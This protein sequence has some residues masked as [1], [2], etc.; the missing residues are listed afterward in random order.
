MR[1]GERQLLS[2]TGR[3]GHRS[4]VAR[5]AR[6]GG[7][8]KEHLAVASGRLGLNYGSLDLVERILRAAGGYEDAFSHEVGDFIDQLDH[9]RGSGGLVAACMGGV[10]PVSGASTPRGCGDPTV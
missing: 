8:F 6:N 1:V 5:C 10:V 7:S 2:P 4:H 3:T 9:G